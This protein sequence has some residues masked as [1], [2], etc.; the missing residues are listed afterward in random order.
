MTDHA[1]SSTIKSRL[2]I[3]ILQE[4]CAI[5]I[6]DFVGISSAP[7]GAKGTA[8]AMATVPSTPFQD[9]IGRVAP[10]AL[11]RTRKILVEEVNITRI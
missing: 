2:E 7:S 11:G 5:T 8:I 10:L 4:I 9:A 3:I 1:R 6:Y